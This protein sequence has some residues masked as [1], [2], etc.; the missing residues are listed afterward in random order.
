MEVT[1]EANVS[2]KEY[3]DFILSTLQSS[4]EA[5]NQ[6]EIKKGLTFEKPVSTGFMKT[7]MCKVKVVDYVYPKIIEMDY[8]SSSQKNSIRY[9]I[10]SKGNDHC[11]VTYRELTYDKNHVLKK[12]SPW[13]EKQ[14]KKKTEKR[15]K[16][17]VDFL[18]KDKN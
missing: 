16:A 10:L 1:I 12:L 13:S 3:F 5:E 15:M 9:V 14:Y 4:L 6:S 8:I 2:A 18:N 17:V 11:E 7:E